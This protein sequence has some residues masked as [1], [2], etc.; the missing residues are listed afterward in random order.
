MDAIADR[1]SEVLVGRCLARE[2]V[3]DPVSKRNPCDVV[4]ARLTS[5]ACDEA[6]GRAPADA[7][8]ARAVRDHMAQNGACGGP[9]LPSC[10]AL[11]LCEVLEAGSECHGTGAQPRPGWC[12]IDPSQNPADDPSLV[13]RCPA[14]QKR[15]IRFV[16]PD[17]RQPEADAAMLLVCKGGVP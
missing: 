1:M 17:N 6:R 9:S 10:D 14:D 12:Y 11:T 8:V 5:V 16:D 2:I 7:A 15:F 13:E 3:I 4:E